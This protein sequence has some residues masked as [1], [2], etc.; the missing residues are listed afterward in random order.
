[1]GDLE[2]DT[3]P[4]GGEGKYTIDI[5]PDWRIWGPNGGYMAAIALR[6]AGME[7]TIDRP[8]S[9]ACHF[10]AMA[11]FEPAEI[12]VQTLQRGRR[13]ESFHVTLRQEGRTVLQAMVRA[14]V[15][16]EGVEHNYAPIPQVRQP[17]EL[18]S[19]HEIFADEEPPV[20]F[21]YNIEGKPLDPE[22]AKVEP[23]PR[24]PPLHEWHRF[25]PTA[26]F[27]DPWVDACRLV[28]MAD[29]FAWPAAAMPHRGRKYMAPNLDV[30]AWFHQPASHEGWLL[31][32]H[33]SEIAMN[34]LVGTTSSVWTR[35]GRLVAT[36]GAQLMCLPSP[37]P[38]D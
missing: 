1:M 28:I 14:A 38:I 29:T 19:Y 30:V 36:G 11:K 24:D 33:R 17:E 20:P 2:L 7:A 32:E 12:E 18:L 31:C 37:E 15:P 10:L 3:R 22:R 27:S 4:R 25:Q 26:T 5:S 23:E 9:I 16:V 21:W 34:G 35:D 6:A 13:A 8:A